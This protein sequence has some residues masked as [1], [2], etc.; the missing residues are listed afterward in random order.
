M[1]Q[2]NVS[3]KCIQKMYPKNVHFGNTFLEVNV[4]FLGEINVKHNPINSLCC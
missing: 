1:Y 4:H 2:K 3:K